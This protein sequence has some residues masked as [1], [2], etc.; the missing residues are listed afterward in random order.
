LISGGKKVYIMHL[1]SE[2]TCCLAIVYDQYSTY[3][4]TYSKHPHNMGRIGNCT[5]QSNKNWVLWSKNI[6]I[7]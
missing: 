4:G 1:N 3:I 2:K 5:G 7:L 6:I